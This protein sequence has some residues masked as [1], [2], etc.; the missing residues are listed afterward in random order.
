MQYGYCYGRAG[1][2]GFSKVSGEISLNIL[3]ATLNDTANWCV[4][5]WLLL[6]WPIGDFQLL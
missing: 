3:N 6:A 4:F 5:V 1:H 2:V